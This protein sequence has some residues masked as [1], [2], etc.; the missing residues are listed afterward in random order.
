MLK[1]IMRNSW[2]GCISFSVFAG[3]AAHA[4]DFQKSPLVN[5][6]G[7][8][9]AVIGDLELG[10]EKKF[11]DVAL[12]SSNA[13]VVFQS[14]GGNLVAGIEI[15]K[16]IHLKGFSTLVPDGMQ[17]ASACALAWLGGST[18]LMGTAARVGFH[19]VYTDNNGQPSVSSAGNAIVG[20]YL[21]QLG[22]PNSAVIYITSAAPN[23]MQWLTFSD[24]QRY[25]I[26]V[27][28]LNVT[29]SVEDAPSSESG[30]RKPNSFADQVKN[31]TYSFV[32]ATNLSNEK[33]LSFLEGKY[34]DRVSYY[35]KDVS[36]SD[37][38]KDKRSFFA[39][40]P[41]R[42]Y[43]LKAETVGVDCQNATSC[44]SS[45]VMTWNAEGRGLAS[46]GSANVTVM[47][48]QQDG[49]W[50]INGENSQ[51][52]DRKISHT[53]QSVP[54]STVGPSALTADR[55]IYQ[56]DT[57]STRV[58]SLSNLYDDQTCPPAGS[59]A[60]TVVQRYF[61]D[62][63]LMLTGV[64]VEASDGSRTFVNVNVDLQRSDMTTRSWVMRG[65]QTLLVEGRSAEVKVRACGAAGRVL[66]L[67]EV[68]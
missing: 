65:L 59:I 29:A 31:E 43:A 33:A 17:C 35:G 6:K 4:A 25:G 63:G 68:R 47:W 48:T 66:G 36:R 53:D 52:I 20:V 49:V 39:K 32:A 67:D 62:D 55:P 45:G 38:L 21:N 61:S 57:G 12:S 8:I 23:E 5:S 19:A 50:R 16:A 14:R 34:S 40:W 37:V 54:T 41:T 7:D 15:G 51:V 1:E 3:N 11:I 56:L 44:K 30:V 46:A 64:V 24:A 26:D 9:I 2:I 22:L 42:R 10:D 58:V 13:V 27:K 18:R 60:G 28:P